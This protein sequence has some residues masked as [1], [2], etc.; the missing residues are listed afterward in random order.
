MGANSRL[1]SA[2]LATILPDGTSPIFCDTNKEKDFVQDISTRIQN[3]D[4]I[5]DDEEFFTEIRKFNCHRNTY[6]TIFSVF[7]SASD[8]IIEMDRGTGSHQRRNAA[9]D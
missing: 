8:R 3:R 9:V 6:D 7:W 1:A 5:H 2:L 4:S